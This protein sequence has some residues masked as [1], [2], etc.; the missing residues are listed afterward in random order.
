MSTLKFR[1]W[2]CDKRDKCGRKL[3]MN[4]FHLRSRR[5]EWSNW[6]RWNFY[7]TAT[8]AQSMQTYI[9]IS[10]GADAS[11]KKERKEQAKSQIDHLRIWNLN[12]TSKFNRHKKAFHF[13]FSIHVFLPFVCDAKKSTKE[14]RSEVSRIKKFENIRRLEQKTLKY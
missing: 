3:I 12:F 8:T 7:I 14:R 13:A 11:Y 4:D 2:A 10:N 6:N 5:F 9:L 1:G